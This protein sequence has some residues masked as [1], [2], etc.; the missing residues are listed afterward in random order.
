MTGYHCQHRAWWQGGWR[1]AEPASSLALSQ[2]LWVLLYAS[3][4][5]APLFLGP[6]ESAACHPFPQRIVLL[7]KKET[8]CPY[9][10]SG[11]KQ[12]RLQ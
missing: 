2:R 10:I 4:C 7:T 1:A 3:L 11:F 5:L 12:N 6:L 8:S 9:Q